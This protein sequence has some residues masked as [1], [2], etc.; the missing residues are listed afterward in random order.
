[1]K[2]E[3]P[4]EYKYCN[5]V[6]MIECINGMKYIGS[7]Y[8]KPHKCL[9][10]QGFNGRYNQY[11]TSMQFN[12]KIQNCINKYG[13]NSLTMKLIEA[14]S[15]ADD[16][17]YVRSREIYYMDFYKT[18]NT[19]RGLNLKLS[20]AG[21]NG[22]A[23]KGKKYPKPSPEIVELRASKIRG[24]PKPKRTEEHGHK[25]SNALKGRKSNSSIRYLITL[26]TAH[27]KIIKLNSFA[28]IKKYNEL[29]ITYF[30]L[31]R[32]VL[33]KNYSALPDGIEIINAS[34]ASDN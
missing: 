26:K 24:I 23:N 11:I 2:F 30:T 14:A 13:F 1:M 25:I 6:Y 27:G 9:H 33:K 21:G 32:C 16:L 19:K 8:R 22:G 31:R 28:D 34:K 10:H 3:I 5:G 12:C 17:N 7:V 29:G 18:V 15:S 4:D 20:A